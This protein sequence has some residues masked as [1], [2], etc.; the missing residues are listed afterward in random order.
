MLLYF[1]C[2]GDFNIYLLLPCKTIPVPREVISLSP[3]VTVDNNSVDDEMPSTLRIL[4]NWSTSKPIL[5]MSYTYWEV[6]DFLRILGNLLFQLNIYFMGIIFF[7]RA[8][9]ILSIV[10]YS[11]SSLFFQRSIAK[12]HVTK[13]VALLKIF[14]KWGCILECCFPLIFLFFCFG[15][16][17]ACATHLYLF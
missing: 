2:L 11:K 6:G 7:W 17:A 8:T 1:N 15:I 5:G 4:Y 3:V 14:P 13:E 12:R 9:F 10:I 16:D